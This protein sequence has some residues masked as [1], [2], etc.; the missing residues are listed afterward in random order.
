VEQVHKLYLEAGFT[1]VKVALTENKPQGELAYIDQLEQVTQ[2]AI[3]RE[4]ISEY[5]LVYGRMA[6]KECGMEESEEL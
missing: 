2:G 6:T 1:Y 5:L 3:T 4:L